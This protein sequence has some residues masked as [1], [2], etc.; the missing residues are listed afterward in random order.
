MNTAN[1]DS[2]ASCPT[3]SS[4]VGTSRTGHWMHLPALSAF[5]PLVLVS[6]AGAGVLVLMR[7]GA[8]AGSGA[9]VKIMPASLCL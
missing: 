4:C 3:T 2:I 1:S 8:G 6:G 5:T 7:C 9:K